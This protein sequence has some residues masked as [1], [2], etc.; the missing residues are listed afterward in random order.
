M[1]SGM[2]RCTTYRMYSATQPREFPELITADGQYD[3]NFK[4]QFF[5]M[6]LRDRGFKRSLGLFSSGVLFYF[7]GLKFSMKGVNGC[8]ERNN[9][10][11]VI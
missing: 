11:G 6:V 7:L 4:P 1:G 8:S 10:S 3:Q 2:M 9:K 5:S